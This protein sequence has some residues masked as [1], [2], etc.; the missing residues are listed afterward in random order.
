ML[1]VCIMVLCGAHASAASP[2]LKT[3]T[4]PISV[5]GTVGLAD[6]ASVLSAYVDRSRGPIEVT[7][8]ER[9]QVTGDAGDYQLKQ[10]N[11]IFRTPGVLFKRAGPQLEITVDPTKPRRAKLYFR[12]KVNELAKGRGRLARH[13]VPR[14]DRDLRARTEPV[15]LGLSRIDASTGGGP[16]VVLVHGL[17]SSPRAFDGAAQ[18][19]ARRGYDVYVFA[20]T[21]N[22]HISDT[23]IALGKELRALHASIEKKISLVTV[24][25]GAII[26]QY[27]LEKDPSYSKEVSRF[28]ACAPPFQGAEMAR[29]RPVSALNKALTGFVSQALVLGTLGDAA[30]DILP[31]SKL[32]ALLKKGRRRAG[33]RYSVIAGN[34]PLMP[35]ALLNAIQGFAKD[36]EKTQGKSELTRWLKGLLREVKRASGGRGDGVVLLSS[37]KLKGVRDRAVLPVHHLQFLKQPRR[38]GEAIPGLEAVVKRLPKVRR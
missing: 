34:A 18:A 16:P 13:R 21:S 2:G 10:W 36:F 32:L 33:V 37:T 25:L 9:A 15:K 19:L 8:E 28:I 14:E 26:A 27:Y 20:Y 30:Q 31:E 29:Y 1:V 12:R 35:D 23:G 11:L 4:V 6:V 24:S 17:D 3:H 22:A 5:D 38:Q 7:T